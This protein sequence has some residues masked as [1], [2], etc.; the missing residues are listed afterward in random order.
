MTQHYDI[1][2]LTD[3]FENGT[4]I[5]FLFF[6]GHTN[7]FNEAAGKFCFSQWYP[8]P[9]T[10]DGVEYKTAEHWMMAQKALLF[11]DEKSFDKIIASKTPAEA[12]KLG[13]LVLRFD[14]IVWN[15][16]GFDIVKQG[17]I[18]K[19]N[20]HPAFAEYLLGTGEK[21]LVEASPVDTI[22]GIGLSMESE[23]IKNIYSWRGL[24]LLG[25]VLMEV[26][27]FLKSFGRFEVLKNAMLP[28]WKKYPNIHPIDMFWRM[29]GGE[30]YVID[31]GKY[32]AALDE[33]S[34]TIYKLTY[35][36]SFEWNNFYSE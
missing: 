10:V 4:A 18:H 36:T 3:T 14:E 1:Q 12:K 21:V 35:P 30:G 22:W 15:A 26:R 33:H 16:K 29:G 19:F 11:D 25:F 5:D 7:K 6:W 20:Q 34:K 13:R 31:F 9:F 27:D 28:P 24:N 32:Y 23:Y 2:W 8:A 17:N